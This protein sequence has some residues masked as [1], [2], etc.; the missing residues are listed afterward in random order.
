V[1]FFVRFPRATPFDVAGWEIA[2]R[3]HGVT[4]VHTIVYLYRGE[5]L[6]EFAAD[7]RRVIRA[8]A[9]STSARWIAT[10]AR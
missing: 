10:T 1:C 6:G 7:A 5:R 2:N 4:A 9:A 8:R 3:V